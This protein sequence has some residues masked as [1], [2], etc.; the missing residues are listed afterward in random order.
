MTGVIIF[1]LVILIIL[2][3]LLDP[4]LIYVDIIPFQLNI[5]F[6]LFGIYLKRSGNNKKK[7]KEKRESIAP[8]D[9]LRNTLPYFKAVGYLLNHSD[10]SASDKNEYD[11][12]LRTHTFTL[13]FAYSVFLFQRMKRRIR[14]RSGA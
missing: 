4:V 9:K 5:N 12:E 7:K 8:I 14:S 13:V 2:T 1:A 10:V 3:L 6:S 11:L